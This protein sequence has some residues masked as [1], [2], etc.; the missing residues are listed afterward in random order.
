LRQ[1]NP[2]SKVPP[3]LQLFEFGTLRPVAGSAKHSQIIPVELH[4][5][6]PLPVMVAQ[7]VMPSAIA[8]Y[9]VKLQ[10]LRGAAERADAAK[11]LK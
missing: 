2:P 4:Q 7:A 3:V 5:I 8:D 10:V 11:L 6:L 1:K 9:E